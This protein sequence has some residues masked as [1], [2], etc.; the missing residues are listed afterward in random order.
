MSNYKKEIRS[1]LIIA[2]N[3]TQSS[4]ELLN[5]INPTSP[6]SSQ[7]SIRQPK[8]NIATSRKLL[9]VQ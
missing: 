3:K 1:Q 2:I 5:V 6:K 4:K 7:K 9:K 8:N